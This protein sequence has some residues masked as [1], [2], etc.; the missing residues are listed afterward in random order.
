MAKPFSGTIN[1]DVTQ[2]VP[3]WA[4]Y[5]QPIAS[6]GTPSVPKRAWPSCVTEPS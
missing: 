3:D 4:P 1:V 5:T 2:S 6:E